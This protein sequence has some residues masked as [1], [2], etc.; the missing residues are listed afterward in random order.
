MTASR[1]PINWTWNQIKGKKFRRKNG[2]V[3]FIAEKMWIDDSYEQHYNFLRVIYR[4]RHTGNNSTIAVS[5]ES[6]RYDWVAA[7]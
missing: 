5:E 1:D 6:F 2:T 7:E 4:M 3:I